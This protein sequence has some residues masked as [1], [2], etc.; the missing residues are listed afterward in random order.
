MGWGAPGAGCLEEPWKG[1]GWHQDNLD[2]W[3]LR[4]AGQCW[5]MGRAVARSRLALHPQKAAAFST[6]LLCLG[7]S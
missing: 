4:A 6:L 1:Y 2:L 3:G 5:A 7:Q